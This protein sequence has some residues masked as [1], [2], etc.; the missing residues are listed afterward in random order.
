LTSGVDK[1]K[2]FLLPPFFEQYEQNQVDMLL[3][4]GADSNTAYPL[5]Y[6]ETLGR[7][8]VFPARAP[9]WLAAK[10]GH[11]GV[12]RL[13]VAADADPNASNPDDGSTPLYAAVEG[14]SETY[15][16]TAG[17]EGWW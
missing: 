7:E 16:Y 5:V 9:L 11:S 8:R 1:H 10:L 12:A 17:L 13:L 2:Y 4:A 14:H 3:K 6:D 15:I